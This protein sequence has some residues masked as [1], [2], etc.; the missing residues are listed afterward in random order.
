LVW[1]RRTRS[2]LALIGYAL[3][4]GRV[5]IG[6]G[7]IDGLWKSTLKL[8]L[9]NFLLADYAQYFSWAPVGSFP[10]E[11]TGILASISGIFAAYFTVRF[12]G[13]APFPISV[14]A[15]T[16]AVTALAAAAIGAVGA[17]SSRRPA[18]PP[19][20]GVIRIGVIA[21]KKGL[22]AIL[23]GSFLKAVE[24]SREDLP[25][26]KY[27]YELVIADTGNNV[28]Q[29]RRA[30]QKLISEDKVQ[31][32]LGGISLP[33][34]VVK[35]YATWAGIPHLC[36]CSV[37]TIGD[38]VYNFTNIPLA[39]D[40][41]VRWVEEAQRRGMKSVALLWQDYRASTAT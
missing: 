28:V 29:T 39:D 41:A 32:I 31:A 26:T 33:G 6:F 14:R 19:E 15:R 3:S 13:A 9:G 25:R 10:F 37:S 21:P 12:L 34:Q 20:G 1:F 7:L 11:V 18:L 17:I 40:E 8:F 4:S 35:P 36:G 27:R 30:I 24:L 5:I 2:P 22:A 16:V 23:G 38:G